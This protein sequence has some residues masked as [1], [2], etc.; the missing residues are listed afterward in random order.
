MKKNSQA[1]SF[2]FRISLEHLSNFCDNYTKV[3]YN[4]KHELQLNRQTYDY[5]IFK[6]VFWQLKAK[7]NW[8][9]CDDICLK[10]HR[11]SSTKQNYINI[12]VLAPK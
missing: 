4:C 2:S 1:G 6:S 8:V 9:W 5:A 10:F 7:F 12:L 11:M 3:I